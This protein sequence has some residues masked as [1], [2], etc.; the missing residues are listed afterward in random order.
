MTAPADNPSKNDNPPEKEWTLMFLIAGDNNLAPVLI[1]Q[2]KA[3]KDAG[4]QK[5]VDVLVHFDPSERRTPTKLLH[6]NSSRRGKA[7]GRSSIGMRDSFVRNMKEDIIS[8][9]KIEA[10]PGS[11]AASMMEALLRPD[12]I[13]AKD[14][15]KN[16]IGFCREKHPAKNYMLFLV[17]HGMVVGNDAFLPDENPKSGLTLEELG[18]ILNTFNLEVD[19]KKGVF[20]LLALHS[21]A[22]SAI[23]VAYQLKGTARYMMGS[24]GISYMGSWPYLNI[25]MRVFSGQERADKK[26]AEMATKAE[27]D[28]TPQ[29]AAAAAVARTEAEIKEMIRDLYF[30]SLFSAK[31]FMYAGYSHDLTLCS[32]EQ[33]RYTPL[34]SAIQT[35]VVSLKK[36]VVTP[37]G[38]DMI[39]VSHWE[40]QSYW[41]ENY[42]DLYDFCFCLERRLPSDPGGWADKLKQACAGVMTVLKPADTMDSKDVILYSENFG[43]QYQYSHGLSVYFPWSRPLDDEPLPPEPVSPLSRGS[44][45]AEVAAGII[46]NYRKYEFSKAL[47]GDSWLS[48]LELYFKETMRETRD[49]EPGRSQEG[50]SVPI[51]FLESDAHMF[52]PPDKPISS[53]DKPIPSGGT[54]CTCPSIKNY[55]TRA[56]EL[57]FKSG[58]KKKLLVK[59][60][61]VS[62]GLRREIER[63]ESEE[64]EREEDE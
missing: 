9:D 50:D 10:A 55:P 52:G 24:E 63:E 40:S 58:R 11:A 26:A 32:L 60:T 22:M 28:V 37:Q 3:I 2:L 21:C 46:E 42:T 15:L 62:V 34:T 12:R 64:H 59:K 56:L 13:P 33:G 7:N 53:G 57:E 14:A 41:E 38:K 25:L 1:S 17:G 35:L 19:G 4:F 20:Q 44:E 45:P 30:H 8:P 61:F 51:S 16:F 48:F 49:E 5:H 43:S 47:A 6:V 23:E 54:G 36:A 29:A 39:L 27:P 31:D 18:V